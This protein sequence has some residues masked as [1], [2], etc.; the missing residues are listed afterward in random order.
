MMLLLLYL[1]CLEL[2]A[3]VQSLKVPLS[4]G[5]WTAGTTAT[6]NL[7]NGSRLFDKPL[8]KGE[9]VEF[10]KAGLEAAI[11]MILSAFAKH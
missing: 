6:T 11:L 5:I 9:E 2:V 7:F 4:C 10:D 8:L 1:I 3:L